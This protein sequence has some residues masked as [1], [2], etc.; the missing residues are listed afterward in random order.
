[1]HVILS[2][3]HDN[4]GQN[5]KKTHM[6]SDI[7]QKASQVRLRKPWMSTRGN[8]LIMHIIFPK[9]FQYPNR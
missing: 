6:D 2:L 5:D 7:A 4:S 9:Y 8:V 1:M 3:P